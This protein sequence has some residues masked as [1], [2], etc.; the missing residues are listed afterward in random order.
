M[1]S[2]DEANQNEQKTILQEKNEALPLN[3]DVVSLA[4][5]SGEILK[6]LTIVLERLRFFEDQ[7][8]W[9]KTAGL[10]G[11]DEQAFL[12][13]TIDH[14]EKIIEIKQKLTRR[15]TERFEDLT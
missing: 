13:L 3:P 5:P 1:N 11:T 9:W 14:L 15:S 7:C 10:A 2:S 4:P 8:V 12:S 6:E